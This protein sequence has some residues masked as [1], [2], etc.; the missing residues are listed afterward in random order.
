MSQNVKPNGFESPEYSAP[1]AAIV[2]PQASVAIV[3]SDAERLMD[4]IFEDVE[5]ILSYSPALPP[6]TEEWTTVSTPALSLAHPVTASILVHQ[7]TRQ[8]D[9]DAPTS[10]ENL[11]AVGVDLPAEVPALEGKKELQV[12]WQQLLERSLLI[13]SCAAVLAANA[14]G[15][16]L[17]NRLSQ[18]SPVA[19]AP[20][21]VQSTAADQ[22]FLDYMQRSLEVLDRKAAVNRQ[23]T[24]VATIPPAASTPPVGSANLPPVPVPGAAQAGSTVLERVYIPVYQPPQVTAAV[25]GVPLQVAPG[26]AVT[27][28]AVPQTVLPPTVAGVPNIAPVSNYSL[29]GVLE[30]GDRSAALFEVNGNPQRVQMGEA[31]GT[32]GW[33]LVTVKNQEAIVRRN[34][35]VRSI[36]IGQRF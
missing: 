8:L 29:I 2:A 25:P 3:D 31:I 17:Q 14:V 16:A 11:L 6:D 18:I 1:T 10:E 4:E 27:V 32:S 12:Q 35:E 22:E 5:R 34:G 13:L 19:V 15:F 7:P 23:T 9:D 36:N 28:P 33:T 30:L 24:A 26:S 21:E 20:A